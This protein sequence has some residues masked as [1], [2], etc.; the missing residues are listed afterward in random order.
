MKQ[1]YLFSALILAIFN[2]A[3]LAQ[4]RLQTTKV[5]THGDSFSAP[6][7][8]LNVTI[9]ESWSG[10]YPHGSEI[11]KMTN[12]SLQAVQCMYFANQTNLKK[13]ISNWKKGFALAQ[14][15]RLELED[16]MVKD[17]GIVVSRVGL[18][19]RADVKGTVLAKCG[20]FGVCVTALVYGPAAPLEDYF[21]NLL[22]LLDAIEFVQPVPREELDQFDWQQELTGKY[23]LA[24]ERNVASKKQSQ[25]WLYLDGTFKSKI[26]RTGL[27]KGA[28]GDYKGTKRGTYLIYNEDQDKPAKL[29]LLF[30]KLPE[31]ELE[32]VRKDEQVYINDQ[33]VFY[34]E[35]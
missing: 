18:T 33:M 21:S 15:L 10:F 27:F 30:N 1:Y 9:P 6:A 13:I 8:G 26:S 19:N 16:E 5:Y 12:D 29:V 35:M 25:V 20:S 28:A 32:L 22:P 23:L 17:E 24:Y 2:H 14:G 3:L 7:Y 11:F 4:E 34:S 31:I